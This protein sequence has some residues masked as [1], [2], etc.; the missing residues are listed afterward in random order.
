MGTYF[1]LV[2]MI[3]SFLIMLSL[4]RTVFGPGI[5]NRIISVNVIGTKAV[6]ILVLMGL[7]YERLDMFVD[8]SLVYALLNFIATLA[9]AKYFE[10]RGV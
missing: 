4:Y 8:I 6:I 3:M 2:G 5:M 7:I 1:L 9:A 10:R